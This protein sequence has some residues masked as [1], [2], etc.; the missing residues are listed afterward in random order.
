M[1]DIA[2]D[3]RRAAHVLTRAGRFLFLRRPLIWLGVLG[4][5]ASVATVLAGAR[6]NATRTVIPLTSWF[7]LIPSGHAGAWV[8]GTVQFV[9]LCVITLLW[10]ITVAINRGG[11]LGETRVWLLAVAWGAPLALGPPLLSGDVYTYAAQ[12]LMARAGVDVYTHG[13]NVLGDIPAVLAV[14]PT[15][16]SSPSPYGPLGTF[17]QHLAAS[18]SGGSA[19]GAVVV[20]RLIA[21]VSVVAIGILAADL[22]GPRRSQALSL[23]V[24]NPLL[25]YQVVSA[26][27]VD[28]ILCAL[29]MGCL[30]AANHRKWA[31]AILLGAAAGGI[32]APGYA[33]V[34]AV[35]VVH[36][37][38]PGVSTAWRIAWRS[39]IRDTALAAAAVVASSAVVLNGWG[40]I[41]NLTTPALGH[42]ALAPASLVADLLDPIVKSASFDDLVTGGRITALAAAGVIIVALLVTAPTRALNRTVGYALI[43]FA[44]LSPVVYPWYLL[45]G[46][47][48]LAPT[49]RQAR[50]DWLVCGCAVATVINPIGMQPPIN[51]VV[52]TCVVIA[53]GLVMAPRVFLRYRADQRRRIHPV[54]G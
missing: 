33:A 25:L 46:C 10:V 11:R 14:D 39:A 48:C 41:H 31:W 19:L 12:G 54:G 36:A 28:G 20:F 47:V 35:I 26:A 4:F 13:P 32:K 21:I 3:A 44:L 51:D 24:I 49:A 6:L 53:A 23:T 7:G 42:T 29:L 27:H 5:V 38:T 37:V 22:A 9:G 52:S 40:W 15:W 18:V 34:L 43:A 2:L 50:L 8:A 30:Y 1:S 45:W 16:R 17:I